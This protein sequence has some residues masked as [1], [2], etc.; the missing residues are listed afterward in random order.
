MV[1]LYSTRQA[2]GLYLPLGFRPAAPR[3]AYSPRGGCTAWSA[4]GREE[5]DGHRVEALSFGDLPELYGVDRWSSGGPVAPNLRHLEI[6]S[7]SGP[8]R[9]GLVRADKRVPGA[10]L[11]GRC[12]L[13]RALRGLEPRR[14]PPPPRLRS[15]RARRIVRGGHRARSSR[16]PDA[17][18]APRIRLQ[19]SQDHLR[20]ELGEGSGGRLS[21]L[22]EQYRTTPYPAT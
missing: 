13:H 16:N 1:G 18:F 11:L 19:G 21:G 6:A 2:E 3:T 8:R 9:P 22:L 12:D 14:G 5:A 17:R 7:G 10:Q 20:M 15:R 4:G